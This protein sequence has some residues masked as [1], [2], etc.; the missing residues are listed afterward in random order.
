M[1]AASVS[2]FAMAALFV[3]FGLLNVGGAHS[4]GCGGGHC[5]TCSTDCDFE[6]RHP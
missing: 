6:G 1:I 4:H 2:V 3:V 5:D